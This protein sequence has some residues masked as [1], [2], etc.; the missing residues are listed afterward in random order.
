MMPSPTFCIPPSP[1]WMKEEANSV[2]R[3][4]VF[5]YLT[6]EPH[7]EDLLEGPDID[8]E[9][10]AAFQPVKVFNFNFTSIMKHGLT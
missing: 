3:S 2:P 5:A 6:R 1:I 8:R 9:G 7:L 10:V 4:A